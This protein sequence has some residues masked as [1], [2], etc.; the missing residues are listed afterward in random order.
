[1][2]NT[3]RALYA[4]C[5]DDIEQFNGNVRNIDFH[6]CHLLI[7]QEISASKKTAEPSQSKAVFL[8]Y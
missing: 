7:F 8:M 6:C 1:M 4:N 3:Y 5:V 2:G